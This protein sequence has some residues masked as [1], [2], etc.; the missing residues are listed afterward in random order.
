[1][2]ETRT[3]TQ[4]KELTGFSGVLHFAKD[5]LAAFTEAKEKHGDVVGWTQLG[6]GYLLVSDPALIE[7]VIQ[8]RSGLVKDYFTRDLGALLGNGL[9]N[10]EGDEWR[11]NRKLIAPTFQP[12]EMARFADTMVTCTDAAVAR[13]QDGEVRDLHVDAMHLTLDVVVRTLFGAEFSR[14]DDVERALSVISR[15]YRRLWQTFR[16]LLPPWWPLASRRRIRKA[17]ERLDEI[18]L[19][20]IRKKREAPGDDLLSQLIALQ[21]DEGKG[22]SD[23]QLRDE[24]MTLFLAGHE[25]TALAFTYIFHLLATSP[26]EYRKHLEEL[27]RVLAGRPPTY[28]DASKLPYTSAVVREGLRLHPPAWSMGRQALPNPT[29][30]AGLQVPARTQ[31]IMSQWVVQRDERWFREPAR[32]RPERWLGDECANLPRFAYF[33]FGGGPRV[34]VG[35]HFALLELLLVVARIGQLVEFERVDEPLK[36][37]PVITLR[38]GGPVNFRVRRRNP[39]SSARDRAAE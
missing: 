11:K 24:A 2:T 14:F 1:M 15:E 26:D 35:Q 3:V 21:D 8:A 29:E 27:D 16:V 5:P 17:R 39:P 30:I 4:A 28:E 22:L 38:P 19:E 20:L 23:S 18:L 36:M 37:A 34:C 32:F 31:V 9:L 25:T 7:A 33:P 12:R 6:A 10:A 13:F